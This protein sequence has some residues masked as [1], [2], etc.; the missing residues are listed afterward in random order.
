MEVDSG[1]QPQAGGLHDFW[2]YL[3]GEHHSCQIQSLYDTLS[4]NHH[5]GKAPVE[6]ALEG[7]IIQE[8]A[9]VSI[10]DCRLLHCVCELLGVK[11]EVVPA[12]D[13]AKMH[14]LKMYEE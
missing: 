3:E 10:L 1:E 12:L 6:T 4:K 8:S 9:K 2:H 7:L 14:D 11:A 5:V 13:D